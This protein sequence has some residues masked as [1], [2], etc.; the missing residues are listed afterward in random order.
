MLLSDNCKEIIENTL[1]QSEN[2]RFFSRGCNK[3]V[4]FGYSGYQNL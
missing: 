1:Q 4:E 2:T 3:E